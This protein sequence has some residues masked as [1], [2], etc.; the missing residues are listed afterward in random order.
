MSDP[1]PSVIPQSIQEEV[2]SALAAEHGP[3][4][5]AS[6]AEGVRQVALAWR[7]TDGS[8][9]EF[10][11]F[12]QRRFIADPAQRRTLLERVED[13]WFQLYGHLGE[14]RRM[15]QRWRDL[16]G[17]E[18]PGI[19][20]LLAEFT[21]APD[22][23]E[24]LYR[25]KLAF[26]VLLNFPRRTL[27]E[28]LASG[29][30]WSVEEWAAARA[31]DAVP[32]RV[33]RSVS[34]LTRAAHQ[35]AIDF[36][37]AFHVPVDCVVDGRGSHP[38]PPGRKLL[39]HWLLRDEIK[40]L[41][42]NKDGLPRQRLLERIFGRYID[43]TMPKAVLAGKARSWCPFSNEVDGEPAAASELVGMQR[44]AVWH[45]LFQVAKAADPYYPDYPRHIERAIELGNQLSVQ[46][47]EAL[48]RNLL[49]A[50]VRRDVMALVQRRL[51]RPLEP[52]D[53]YFNDITPQEPAENLH[54]AVC[55]RFAAFDDFQRQLP[56]ILKELGFDGR[57]ADFLARHIQ[58]DPA[59]GYGHASP[60][61]LPEYPSFLRTN[62]VDNRMN[63]PALNCSMHELGHCVEQVFGLH[64]A[65][66]RMLRGRPNSAI[67]EA[68]AFTF[69]T[70]TR[71]VAGIAYPRGYEHAATVK[72]Y[73]SACEI[74]GAALVD[75]LVWR[76]LYENPDASV[77]RLRDEAIATADRVWQEYFQPHFG[78]D[79]N[80]LLAAYQHM[81]SMMLYLPNYVAGFVISHQIRRHLKP[82]TL[83]AEVERMCSQGNLSP[84]LWMQRAVGSDISEEG[85][86]Q[87]VRDALAAMKQDRSK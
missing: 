5:Q 48:L 10:R 70:Y 73:L 45:E 29:P 21:P 9:E 36:I 18:D 67:T 55:R 75:L 78:P 44:Y 2:V 1:H 31:A 72:E 64:R 53:I 23:S 16:E 34:D 50:D 79:P 81:V 49:A 84:S 26:V 46:R 76:W 63:W 40:N 83:A 24:E 28:K 71:N 11:S 51:G 77:Q 32:Y 14:M 59:R 47:V 41:Y 15:F 82:E 65:P 54:A 74:A 25:S 37:N 80:H 27:A 22:L 17:C 12:V 33:P 30:S 3:G 61:G 86:H 6:A 4:V 35:R 20:D 58:V 52:F 87:D 60:A 43:G 85:L 68:V 19:D 42:G 69:Q 7:E 8:I 57:T 38:F 66:R 39:V 13:T 56:T 62:R